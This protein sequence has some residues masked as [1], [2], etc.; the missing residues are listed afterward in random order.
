MNYT[1]EIT[2]QV[3]KIIFESGDGE[4]FD[5]DKWV[6]NWI[7]SP[8]PALGGRCPIEFLHNDSDY[9]IISEMI[10]RMQTGAYS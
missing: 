8:I 3:K 2:K 1:E 10:S 7:H 5:V 9:K 4:N 6:Y